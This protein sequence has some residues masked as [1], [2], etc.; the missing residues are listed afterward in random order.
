MTRHFCDWCGKEQNPLRT[1][2]LPA[3]YVTMYMGE[4][5]GKPRFEPFEIKVPQ[6][7]YNPIKEFPTVTTSHVCDA[8][9]ERVYDL[10]ETIKKEA[11]N[12]R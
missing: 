4:R 7:W 11:H 10:I 9:A 5:I 6:W 3:M 12:D 8:C 2:T 1:I